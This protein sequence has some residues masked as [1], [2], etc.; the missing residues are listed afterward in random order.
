MWN[1]KIRGKRWKLSLRGIYG[2]KQLWHSRFKINALFLDN[3]DC[4]LCNTTISRDSIFANHL[5]LYSSSVMVFASSFFCKVMRSCL[6]LVLSLKYTVCCYHLLF[7][8]CFWY[9]LACI[10]HTPFYAFVVCFIF[11]YH[12]SLAS[13][14]TT[15]HF[16]YIGGALISQRPTNHT[17][18]WNCRLHCKTFT[19][20]LHKS[21]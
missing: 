7:L 1:G 15:T 4:S 17:T 2:L 9:Y 8:T 18:S 6:S 12:V 21:W 10:M 3:C 11:V 20:T 19:G 16:M 14:C 13:L 5:A